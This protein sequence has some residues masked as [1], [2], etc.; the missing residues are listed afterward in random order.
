MNVFSLKL[1]KF[2]I[3]KLVLLFFVSFPFSNHARG[4]NDCIIEP[5]TQYLDTTSYVF[6]FRVDSLIFDSVHTELKDILGTNKTK[7]ASGKAIEIF[8]KS[9]QISSHEDII[10]EWERVF[11]KGNMF[12]L[13][14]HRVKNRNVFIVNQCSYSERI[15]NSPKLKSLITTVNSYYFEKRL[16]SWLNDFK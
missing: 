12:L 8:Q 1:L 6:I 4:Q 15:D 16:E 2:F 11:S 7:L 13:F 3:S 14:C 5:I 9:S 10:V